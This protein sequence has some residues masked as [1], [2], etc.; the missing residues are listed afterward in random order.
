MFSEAIEGPCG[1]LPGGEVPAAVDLVV[2]DEVG[3]G[4]LGP[5]ARRLVD[6]VGEDAH[7]N[8]DG[9]V[10]DGEVAALVLVQPLPVQ[11]PGGDARVRQPEQR[12]VVEDV[13]A[14]QAFLGPIDKDAR[15]QLQ[16]R[17]VVVEHERRQL[18][19]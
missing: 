10:L 14:G 1:P 13:V 12:D 18:D 5:A 11:P 7:G 2:V 9:D 8:R 16:A 4:L 19:G 17:R 3:E 15:D 6:L